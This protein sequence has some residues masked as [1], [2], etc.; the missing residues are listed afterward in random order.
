MEFGL[1]KSK[2]EKKLTESYS[3]NTFN[4]EIKSLN[5]VILKDSNLSKAYHIYNELS[6]S[7][8]FDN[9]FAEDF[10]NECEELFSRL[11]FSK[12]SLS[13]LESWVKNIVCE[14]Q[15][16]DVDTIL[17][18]NTLIIENIIQ[19]KNR[20]INNLTKTNLKKITVFTLFLFFGLLTNAFAQKGFQ[21]G[22]SGF[23]TFN[24]GSSDLSIPDPTG[25]IAKSQRKAN[26]N[27]KKYD[28][29][30]SSVHDYPDLFTPCK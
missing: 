10:V 1:L 12:K 26:E 4:K 27:S 9:K 2:I 20:V 11:K 16:K 13:I 24:M 30:T 3:N 28:R 17:G 5:S 29:G 18:K 7:K 15:Y 19:S 21:L 6:K 23:F 22:I 14:N 25:I 8:G